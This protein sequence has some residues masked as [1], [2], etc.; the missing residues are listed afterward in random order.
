MLLAGQT[1]A[2]NVIKHKISLFKDGDVLVVS[3]LVYG[4]A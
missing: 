2:G 1:S 4:Q 3:K